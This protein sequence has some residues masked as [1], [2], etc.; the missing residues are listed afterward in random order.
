LRVVARQ[1]PNGMLSARTAAATAHS[2]IVELC[3]DTGPPCWAAP[4]Q[5]QGGL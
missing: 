1:Y 5:W 3:R 4:Q 2:F